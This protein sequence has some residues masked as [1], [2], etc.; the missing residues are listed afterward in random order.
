MKTSRSVLGTRLSPQDYGKS[1]GGLQNQAN[2]HPG[3]E[4]DTV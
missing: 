2:A 3:Y 1:L 4:S